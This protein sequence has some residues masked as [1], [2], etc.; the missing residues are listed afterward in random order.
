MQN[1]SLSSNVET[2]FDGLKPPYQ[3]IYADPPWKFKVR[4]QKG[5]AKSPSQH[6]QVMDL[7]WIKSLP[8]ASLADKNCALFLWTSGPHLLESL[9][10]M[11]A[12]GFTYSTVVFD[13]LKLNPKAP[14]NLIFTEQDL[15]F[16]MGYSSRKNAEYVLLGRKG[17][18]RR[19]DASVRSTIIAKRRQHSRKPDET[20]HR[21]ERL[22]QGP[23]VE[24]FARTAPSNWDVWGN[25]LDMFEP[26]A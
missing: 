15:C 2:V 8:V 12:W 26:G 23:Y 21:I 25:D 7:D 20:R 18:Q 16:G 3:V 6:Y 9:E 14:S 17:R 13:W 19:L 4:S 10:V 11:K 1:Q 5:E 24:L 22:Y